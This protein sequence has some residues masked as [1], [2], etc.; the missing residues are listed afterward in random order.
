VPEQGG[1]EGKKVVRMRWPVGLLYSRVASA[2]RR[3]TGGCGTRVASERPPR[4]W[5][6]D[7]RAR[8]RSER[9]RDGRANVEPVECAVI[10]NK[11]SFQALLH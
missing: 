9:A 5:L 4:W 3:L 7:G 8:T 11:P 6:V 10:V 2:P 1:G